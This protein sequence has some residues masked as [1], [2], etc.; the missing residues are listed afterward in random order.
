MKP[1]EDEFLPDQSHIDWFITFAM[2][3]AF[4]VLVVAVWMIVE[5]A[6]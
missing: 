2:L 4:A 3:A 1:N 6:V 5:E